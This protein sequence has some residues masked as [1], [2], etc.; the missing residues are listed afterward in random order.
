M[1]CK[2]RKGELHICRVPTDYKKQFYASILVLWQVN[3]NWLPNLAFFIPDIYLN[4][5]EGHLFLAVGID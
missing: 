2:G 4:Y 1:H 3:S 5:Q